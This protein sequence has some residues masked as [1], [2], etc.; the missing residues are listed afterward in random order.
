MSQ[1]AAQGRTQGS[2]EQTGRGPRRGCTGHI[3]SLTRRRLWARSFV[4]GYKKININ[5]IKV[6]SIK[7]KNRFRVACRLC[8]GVVC[9]KRE[10]ARVATGVALGMAGRAVPHAG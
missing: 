6:K 1:V 9:G 3:R 4:Y 7:V 10:K 2:V 5:S 8:F